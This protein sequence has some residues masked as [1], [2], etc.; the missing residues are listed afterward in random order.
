MSPK[1]FYKILEVD[2]EASPDIVEAAYRR[3]AR[4]YHPDL[5]TSANATAQMQEL[6][7][8]YA[9]LRDPALR[10]KY[11]WQL[12][13]VQEAAAREAS[14]REASAREG[15]RRPEPS[16]PASSPD[17]QTVDLMARAA[18][19]RSAAA[20]VGVPV[21]C[22]GCGKSDST[23]RIAS[24]PYVTSFLVFTQR[25]EQRGV[26]CES[27]RHE[28]M[29][30]AKTH[31]AFA[32]WWGFPWGIFYTMSAL[33]APDDGR[34]NRD[35]NADYLRWL[36][37][38]FVNTGNPVEALRAFQASL[39]LRS[40][41]EL[42]Q[43]VR[44]AFGRSAAA[45]PTHTSGVQGQT[46]SRKGYTNTTSDST[47]EARRAPNKSTRRNATAIIVGGVGLLVVLMLL[48]VNVQPGTQKN[49]SGARPTVKT[50]ALSPTS[51]P[52]RQQTVRAIATWTPQPAGARSVS[53]PKAVGSLE[54]Q[55]LEVM[56][57]AIT[58]Q[59]PPHWTVVRDEE[60]F[61]V[62][63]NTDDVSSKGRQDW[64]VALL[65]ASEAYTIGEF[66]EAIQ[67]SAAV[68]EG[69]REWMRDFLTDVA[70]RQ[71]AEVAQVL[72]PVVM[73]LGEIDVI[74]VDAILT[75]S[76]R[77]N[78][79]KQRMSSLLFDCR[80]YVCSLDYYRADD[81][82]L[83]FYESLIMSRVVNSIIVN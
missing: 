29:R 77:N 43:T 39:A 16:S 14:A 66:M 57:G 46:N 41:P 83:S 42:A 26:F 55:T 20:A 69:H 2:T 30:K 6:N 17:Y 35:Q 59:I 68:R 19:A 76:K 53:K 22:Q 73:Q 71:D 28:Q 3:L 32:G 24:F 56:Q 45:G 36:G 62:I 79:Q 82:S 25:R 34:M 27:C 48:N 61:A 12:R 37:G 13:A 21:A 9:T 64:V 60:N 23:L 33:F 38:F 40:D 10:T 52:K 81:S 49:V 8:A 7:L 44:N 74:R 15:T 54:W 5:N 72:D 67:T 70:E 11:D 80:K 78:A 58:M 63:S 75:T 1:S 51:V 47:S 50:T 31:T 65:E 4:R 18:A